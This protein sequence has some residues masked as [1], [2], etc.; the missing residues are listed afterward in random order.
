MK[1]SLAFL[2]TVLLALSANVSGAAIPSVEGAELVDR[3]SVR[4]NP[5]QLNSLAK[6]VASARSSIQADVKKVDSR[7]RSTL[8]NWT[9]SGATAYR[10]QLSKMDSDAK[11]LA[12]EMNSMVKRLHSVAKSASG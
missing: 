5:S 6:V 12:A 8:K 10:R 7:S 4:I 9:G 11:K 1:L 2:S 3:G